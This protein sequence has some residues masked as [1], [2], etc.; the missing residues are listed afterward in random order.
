MRSNYICLD[1][2]HTFT[3]DDRITDGK[4]CP[5]CKG[6]LCRLNPDI[7]KDKHER[8]KKEVE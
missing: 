2:G 4:N 6:L 1:C 7:A 8:Y 3:D 5:R